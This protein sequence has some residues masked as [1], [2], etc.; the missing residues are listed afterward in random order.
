MSRFSMAIGALMLR[1]RKLVIIVCS[2]HDKPIIE[3][4][5][6]YLKPLYSA[7]AAFFGAEKHI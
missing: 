3:N 7:L 2:D 1:L 6:R 4:T 5:L